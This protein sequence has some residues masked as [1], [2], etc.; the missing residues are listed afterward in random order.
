[1]FVATLFG[2]LCV[3]HSVISVNTNSTLQIVNS[4]F[5]QVAFGENIAVSDDW[6][7]TT[8]AS[9]AIISFYNH[10]YSW[11]TFKYEWVF[12]QSIQSTGVGVPVAVNDEYAFFKMY[13]DQTVVI[14]KFNDVDE[15]WTKDHTL[16]DPN[17]FWNNSFHSDFGNNIYLNPVNDIAVITSADGDDGY[18][19]VVENPG[20]SYIYELDGGS[21]SFKGHIS[22]MFENDQ[23]MFGINGGWLDNQTLVL[24]S[25][26][27]GNMTGDEDLSVYHFES[28]FI[29]SLIFNTTLS[30]IDPELDI[31]NH[32]Y[33]YVSSSSTPMMVVS[34]QGQNT[35]KVFQF[36]SDRR[37]ISLAYNV[38]ITGFNISDQLKCTSSGFA[39]GTLDN[40]MALYTFNSSGVLTL[41]TT[42]PPVATSGSLTMQLHSSINDV[43]LFSFN[44]TLYTV[45]YKAAP[46]VQTTPRPTIFPTRSPVG[47]PTDP[48]VGN[49][50]G[51]TPTATASEDA[52]TPETIVAGVLG[53]ILFAIIVG[54]AVVKYKTWTSGASKVSTD[55]F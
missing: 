33:C 49:A 23:D 54:L 16:L 8:D 13:D 43:Y 7:V 51:S 44:N 3:I 48:P 50:P 2:I 9:G 24:Q 40:S 28:S 34:N 21:W 11:T 45:H 39:V 30:A 27:H 53:A 35:L 6:M 36:G 15:T 19:V 14:Y 47:N 18:Y 12:F 46:S 17:A 52:V 42:I 37:S 41:D 10:K 25:N 4:R 22:E 29:R 31:P 38:A 20:Y 26:I 1:M 5:G 32:S 55:G